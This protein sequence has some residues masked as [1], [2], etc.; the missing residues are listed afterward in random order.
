M[1][2]DVQK[3]SG[4]PAICSMNANDMFIGEGKGGRGRETGTE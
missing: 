4:D 2:G 1:A 3:D